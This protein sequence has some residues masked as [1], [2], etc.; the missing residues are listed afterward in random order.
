MQKEIIDKKIKQYSFENFLNVNEVIKKYG[1]GSSGPHAFYGTLKICNDVEKIIANYFEKEDSLITQHSACGYKSI[2]DYI[3]SIDSE[4]ILTDDLNFDASNY[5]N[6][7]CFDASLYL[8]KKY[9][10]LNTNINNYYIWPKNYI[11]ID[12]YKTSNYIN[13]LAETNHIDIKNDLDIKG[14]ILISDKNTIFIGRKNIKSYVFSATLPAFNYY[15]I[16][17]FFKDIKY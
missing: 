15:L 11:I 3:K 8:A 16:G 17:T 9:L 4:F 14:T 10:G 5:E 7:I 13:Q 6:N 12:L 2:I 1:I